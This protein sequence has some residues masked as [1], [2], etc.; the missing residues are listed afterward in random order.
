MAGKKA[1]T[2]PCPYEGLTATDVTCPLCGAG[3][4]VP[5]RG[6]FGPVYKCDADVRPKCK[7]QLT[8]RPTG[9]VCAYLRHN[10]EPCG[11]LMVEG[12]K[13]IPERCSDRDCP[14]RNPHKLATAAE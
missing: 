4:L 5:A 2:D 12:T 9:R 6:R 1:A 14:N 7:V 13:T 3:K 10:G 11:A 8:S